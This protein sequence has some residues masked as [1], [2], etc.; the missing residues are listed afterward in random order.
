MVVGWQDQFAGERYG[1]RWE[2]G[3]QS[4]FTYVDPA[5][6]AFP[7][8]EALTTNDDG[9]IIVGST[10]FGGDNDGWRWD[11]STGL[12]TLL[13]NLPGQA[14]NQRALPTG[15]TDDGSWICGTNGGSPFTRRAIL[16][17]DGV[18][19]DLLDYLN[20]LGTPG[21][22]GYTTL[23]TCLGMSP[24]GRVIVGFGP[25]A[26]FGGPTGGWVVVL[27]ET[28]PSTVGV[29]YCFGDGSGSACPCGNT[30]AA[31]HGCAS[32]TDATGGVLTSTG[33]A[34]VSDD[35]LELLGSHMGASNC[36][37]F[38]GTAQAS[39]AV[40]DGIRCVGGASIRLGVETNDVAGSSSYPNPGSA[41][42]PV[43]VKGLIPGA[44]GTFHYQVWYRDNDAGFCTADTSNY[45][46]GYSVTWTP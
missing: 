43:S 16:W 26:T 44:G 18:A 37:Y 29:P 10:L 27:P 36:I 22:A 40:F 39:V 25:G 4:L 2:N 1:A 21:L 33:V 9:S 31:G 23:G 11:A 17:I 14:F 35:S 41:D 45:T 42:L 38:Q 20:S 12:V 28:T 7:C 5:L 6:V 24:D 8:G 15:M 13:P 46:S 19:N 32:S 3:V 34:S 30:G